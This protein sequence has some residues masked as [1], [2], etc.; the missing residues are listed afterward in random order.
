MRLHR[1]TTRC[2]A[3][4]GLA[5]VDAAPSMAGLARGG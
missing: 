1:S 2:P 3:A 5:D 4:Q